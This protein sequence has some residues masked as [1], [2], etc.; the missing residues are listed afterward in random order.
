MLL[1]SDHTEFAQHR[2]KCRYWPIS[3]E[4]V[5]RIQLAV[6]FWGLTLFAYLDTGAPYSI[7]PRSVALLAQSSNDVDIENYCLGE[8]KIFGFGGR[9]IPGKMYK[10]PIT[11]TSTNPEED[12]L[13]VSKKFLIPDEIYDVVKGDT[14]FLG[15]GNC[16]EE[17]RFAIDLT[18]EPYHIYIGLP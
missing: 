8:K 15:M 2:I 14:V 4:T 3:S 7:I 13:T 9:D 17:L 11:F 16:M 6:E 5:N 10:I 12:S 18:K 1:F